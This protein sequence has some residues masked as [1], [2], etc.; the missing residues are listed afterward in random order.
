METKT[1]PRSNGAEVIGSPEA[2]AL[3]GEV[4]VKEE[5]LEKAVRL[6]LSNASMT[7]MLT[8][9]RSSAKMTNW[10]IIRQYSIE[11]LISS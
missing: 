9:S 3:E 10:R 1:P 2:Q 8:K 11:V 6:E 7:K 4:I 5:E